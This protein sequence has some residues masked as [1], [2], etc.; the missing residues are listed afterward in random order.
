MDFFYGLTRPMLSTLTHAATAA[1]IRA[2]FGLASR[3]S[4][5]ILGV[6]P[7]PV[8]E[9]SFDGFR[10]QVLADPRLQ[11][12]LRDFK[13]LESFMAAAIAL[14]RRCG[15]DFTENDIRLAAQAA[16]RRWLERWL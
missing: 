2:T 16:H 13:D 1:A 4:S 10:N 6:V 9:N 8:F 7:S 11:A 3:R 14:G 15:Y 12:E 5:V